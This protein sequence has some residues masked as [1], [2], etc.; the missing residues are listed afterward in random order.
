MVRNVSKPLVVR[1]LG[2]VAALTLAVGP[3]AGCSRFTDV[4]SVDAETVEVTGIAGV[5]VEGALNQVGKTTEY[6]PSYVSIEYPDGDVP[7]KTGVCSDVVVRA[8]RHAGY[9]LQRLLHEDMAHNFAAYPQRWGA[10]QP[11]ANIDHRRVPNLAAYFKRQGGALRVSHVGA[12]YLPGDVVTW[13]IDGSPH[14]GL[15]SNK[16]KRGDDHFFIVNNRGGG[17]RVE[18]VLFAWEITGHYRW[19]G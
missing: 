5:L 16:R 8:Y 7:M 4:G 14:T 6:D 10:S 3:L 11:D 2:V 15:V 1:L 13:T 12:D 9:D 19:L 18:D 17:A